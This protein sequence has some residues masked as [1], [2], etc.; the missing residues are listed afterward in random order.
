MSPTD[1]IAVIR[2]ADPVVPSS[3][4]GF[5]NS[6]TGRAILAR[7]VADSPPA[8]LLPRRATKRPA[9]RVLAV[10]VAAA[11][12]LAAA[13]TLTRSPTSPLSA[14]CYQT[15]SQQADTAVIDLG[16]D[17]RGA[18]EACAEVWLSAFGDPVP[19]SLVA[20]VVTG[21]GLGVFPADPT[22]PLDD[23]CTALGA[24]TPVDGDYAGL[25][26]QEVRRLQASLRERH[27]ELLGAGS[28]CVTATEAM[29]AFD[30]TI[31]EVGAITWRTVDVS[32]AA[33]CT[34]FVIDAT[35]GHVLV[36]AETPLE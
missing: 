6:P 1:P 2:K 33:P 7:I 25:G 20:C 10:G 26:G 14:G 27:D 22:V 23:F 13:V 18:V 34:D 11:A 31:D 8:P 9:L 29:V 4:S 32:A 16:T 17:G 3:I 28:G 21:G 30:L 19:E 5:G 15:A 35:Q 24:A 12:M 36:I